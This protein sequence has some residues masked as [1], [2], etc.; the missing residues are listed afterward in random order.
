MALEG[1]LSSRLQLAEH[2]QAFTHSV[3]V[4]E[5]AS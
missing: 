1:S 5:P 3:I 2:V 4:L